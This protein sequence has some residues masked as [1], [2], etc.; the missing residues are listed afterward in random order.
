VKEVMECESTNSKETKEF[1]DVVSRKY[2][3]NLVTHTG[4]ATPPLQRL[5][6]RG[7]FGGFSGTQLVG[8]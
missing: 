6:S 3:A 2:V 8:R 7:L 4:G 1:C 5:T